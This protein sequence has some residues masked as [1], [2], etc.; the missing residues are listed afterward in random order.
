MKF[1]I[2]FANAGTF[3]SAEPRETLVS[4][5]LT[6]NAQGRPRDP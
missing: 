5:E 6:R 2:M 4:T 3:A 1:G